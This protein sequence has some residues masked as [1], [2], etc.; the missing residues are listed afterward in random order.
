MSIITWNTEAVMARYRALK[1]EGYDGLT[2]SRV[3]RFEFVGDIPNPL[4]L[5]P[6]PLKGSLRVRGAG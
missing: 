5:Q 1:E 4:S 2:A 6:S 3:V